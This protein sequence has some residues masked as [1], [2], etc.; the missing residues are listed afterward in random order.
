[1]YLMLCDTVHL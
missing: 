1:M